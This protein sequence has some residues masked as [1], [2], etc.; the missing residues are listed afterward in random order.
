[1]SFSFKDFLK[2]LVVFA[3]GAFLLYSYNTAPPK[4]SAGKSLVQW[5]TDFKAA[6]AL[7]VKRNKPILVNF[8]G[9]D[10]CILCIRLDAEVFNTKKF[11]EWATENV[12][13]MKADFPNEALLPP[14]EVLQ[15]QKLQERYSVRGFPTIL[16]LDQA[17][18]VIGNS[19]YFSGGPKVWI[20]SA[21]KILKK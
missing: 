2:T 21:E 14:S 10:W 6:Q 5:E 20:D 7:S 18:K 8:T 13:L 4:G 1:M 12:I 17:G 3:I 9:S 19:G 11:A 15:N 16:F